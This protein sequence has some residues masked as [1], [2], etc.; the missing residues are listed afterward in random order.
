MLCKL[1]AH[2]SGSP[3]PF[4]VPGACP[5]HAVL[6]LDYWLTLLRYLGMRRGGKAGLIKTPQRRRSSLMD[7]TTPWTPAESFCLSGEHGGIG[8]RK[9]HPLH[10]IPG[11]IW[12]VNICCLAFTSLT[13]LC[14]WNLLGYATHRWLERRCLLMAHLWPLGHSHPL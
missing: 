12:A 9:Q 11:L 2:K 4:R 14:V 1:R 8:S 10:P 7:I 13:C 5:S 6:R 3:G